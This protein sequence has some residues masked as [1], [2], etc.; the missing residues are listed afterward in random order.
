MQTC[1][2]ESKLRKQICS[3]LTFILFEEVLKFTELLLWVRGRSLSK[4]LILAG[5]KFSLSDKLSL[6]FA[7]QLVS[8]KY[9]QLKVKIYRIPIVPSMN[10]SRIALVLSQQIRKISL[11]TAPDRIALHVTISKSQSARENCHRNRW[12]TSTKNTLGRWEKFLE[13]RVLEKTAV[14]LNQFFRFKKLFQVHISNIEGAN[15]VSS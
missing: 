4:R 13:G 1:F 12:L 5:Q 2:N 6:L 15:G 3:K 8:E 14:I 10:I 9:S 7:L 11:S